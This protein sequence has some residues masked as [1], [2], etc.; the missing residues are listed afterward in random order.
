MSLAT[1]KKKSLQK[2]N[3]MSVGQKNFSLNGTHRNQGWVGQ[4]TLSRSLPRTL[5]NGPTERGCGGCCGTYNK[6]PIVTSAVT[7]TNDNSVIK[8]SVL[9]YDGMIATQFRWIRRPQPYTNVKPDTNHNLNDQSDYISRLT[10]T[11]SACNTIPSKNQKSPQRPC[12]SCSV[13]PIIFKSYSNT[14]QSFA[15]PYPNSITK[16]ESDYVPISQGEYLEQLNGSCTKIDVEFQALQNLSSSNCS[17]PFA[18]TTM[19]N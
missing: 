9:S 18:C 17:V 5:M 6:T 4:T 2:Y 3:N 13:D 12:N 1:L 11:R 15:Q 19:V 14:P 7:S 16:P 8:S 10:R